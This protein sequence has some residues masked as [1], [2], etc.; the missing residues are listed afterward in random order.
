MAERKALFAR[1]IELQREIERE[2][3]HQRNIRA[4]AEF[5]NLL[6][7][8]D[9]ITGSTRYSEA[10]NMLADEPAF[11][12]VENPRERAGLYD[13][14]IF[15]L[16]KKEAVEH[17]QR[18]QR[19]Y[20]K[21]QKLFRSLPD[22]KADTLWRSAQ[23]LCANKLPEDEDL[24]ALTPLEQLIGFETY[25]RELE[26]KE[27][28]EHQRKRKEIRR[29]ERINRKAFKQLLKELETKG[30][31]TACTSWKELYPRICNRPEYTAILG[32]PGSTPLDLFCDHL[33]MLQEQYI[34][35][36][37]VLIDRFK[38]QLGPDWLVKISP[39]N[40]PK[41]ME[42]HLFPSR[43]AE[44]KILSREELRAKVD[45]Y[46]KENRKTIDKLKHCIKHH[47][48]PIKID[49]I[50]ENVVSGLLKNPDYCAVEDEAIR[51]YY[52][53]KFI[54]HLRKKAGLEVDKSEEEN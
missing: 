43:P 29:Q 27:D 21:L 3:E 14:F 28:D 37:Q 13:D 25:I 31:F 24:A 8:C 49:S 30:Q 41:K 16:R 47:D 34:E 46:R 7:S 10:L 15:G 33:H 19:G 23:S 53:D 5:L 18:K 45:A 1:H 17:K 22:I 6:Q 36:A 52:Y 12:A 32:Q 51:K 26:R 11:R 48:P 40:V 2:E 38:D 50:Y 20:E 4:R 44:T 35:E 54:R 42:A 39:T 9:Q